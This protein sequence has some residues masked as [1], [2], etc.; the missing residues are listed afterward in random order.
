M[1]IA[2]TEPRDRDYSPELDVARPDLVT[3]GNDLAAQSARSC[4][5]RANCEQQF[6]PRSFGL[7]R[8]WP[9]RSAACQQTQ[10]LAIRL[11]MGCDECLDCRIALFNK[12]REPAFGLCLL[13]NPIA[14]TALQRF[15]ALADHLVVL[16]PQ[17]LADQP[18]LAS[19]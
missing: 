13:L 7:V 16:R 1:R 14:A 5:Q 15:D 3:D 18:I 8:R 11:W 19:P 10:A 17:E 9:L 2:E 4:S 6:P 12:T